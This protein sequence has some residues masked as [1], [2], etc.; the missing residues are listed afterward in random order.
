MSLRCSK[1]AVSIKCI[2]QILYVR[3]KVLSNLTK[4]VDEESTSEGMTVNQSS[5]FITNKANNI[6]QLYYRKFHDYFTLLT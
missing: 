3:F 2:Q 1:A 4:M 5:V 6:N